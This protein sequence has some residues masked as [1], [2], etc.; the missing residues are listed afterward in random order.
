[1]LACWVFD[2]NGGGSLC[3]R[4][5]K[6]ITAGPLQLRQGVVGL[7]RARRGVGSTCLLALQARLAGGDCGNVSLLNS[8]LSN[9]SRGGRARRCGRG[10]GGAR[11]AAQRTPGPAFGALRASPHLL[12]YGQPLYHVLCHIPACQVLVHHH[13]QAAADGLL[14][15]CEGD[16]A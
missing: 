12:G 2:L 9:P 3:A 14:W 4:A 16:A 15:C 6:C 11:A 10:D 1:M 8:R 7:S 13:R 5:V